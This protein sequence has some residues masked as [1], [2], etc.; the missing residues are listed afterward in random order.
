MRDVHHLRFHACMMT[1]VAAAV[2]HRPPSENS[3]QTLVAVVLRD[4]S[5]V[6]LEKD[7]RK[8]LGFRVFGALVAHP[9]INASLMGSDWFSTEIRGI[10]C[11]S[12]VIS[13]NSTLYRLEGPAAAARH[14]AQSRLADIMQPF[15]QS[16]WPPNAHA[17]LNE[18]SKFFSAEQQAE[19]P[20]QLPQNSKELH[21]SEKKAVSNDVNE[22]YLSALAAWRGRST[23][24]S[25]ERAVP[26]S[27]AKCK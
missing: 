17:L 13:D 12:V 15:C 2:A 25:G 8:H 27:T 11:D 21:R 26:S 16:M 19:L 23:R 14:N 24:S 7:V 20:F 10:L 18:V 4:W 9:K 6:K 5:F 1:C 22:F 3:E